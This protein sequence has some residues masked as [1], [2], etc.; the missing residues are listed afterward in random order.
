M[1]ATGIIC[2]YN[3]FHNGHAYQIK[4]VRDRGTDVIV[5]LMS[6]HATQRGALASFN[7]YDRAR[8]ALTGGADVVLE[9]PYPYAAASAAY[10]AGAGVCLLDALG[11]D[12]ICFGSECGSIETLEKAVA[13][14]ENADIP[15]SMRAMQR[16]GVGTA[17]AFFAS[18]ASGAEKGA[19]HMLQ[20]NDILAVEYLKAM[21]RLESRMAVFVL[22]R[23]GTDYHST[24]ALPGGYPSATA[25]RELLYNGKW[26]EIRRYA[27]AGVVRT[28]EEAVAAGRA[29]PG[30]D[31]L[32]PLILGYLRAVSPEDLRNIAEVGGGLSERLCRVAWES[33]TLTDFYRRLACKTYTNA[34]L[35][36][37]VLFSLT[38]VTEQDLRTP[39]AYL[40]LL[41]ATE[42][43]KEWLSSTK[44]IRS[45]PILSKATQGAL[46]GNSA[47]M[48]QYAMSR[49]LDGIFSLAFEVP[50]AADKWI[51]T[52]PIV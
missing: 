8:M 31:K 20:S 5:A 38:G 26:D 17:A 23:E 33:N 44:K 16:K 9:L 32:A 46:R 22:K 4:C 13:L 39:P 42:R 15:S 50:Q 37:A 45:V 10:F 34:R 51:K 12:E 47:A 27:P 41:G 43:G 6:G 2:E 19:A 24:Q 28:M 18:C 40:Q 49:R 36:R 25:M 1:K 35:R 7:K 14:S 3:P 11:I 52:S 21:K 30:E 48:R 29:L